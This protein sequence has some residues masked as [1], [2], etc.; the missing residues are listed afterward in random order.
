[1]SL[2]QE[3][4]PSDVDEVLKDFLS[5]KFISIGNELNQPS[6]FPIRK[7]MPYKAQIGDVHYF[8]NPATHNYDAAITVEGFWGLK[9]SGWV[10][11]G[12]SAV[13]GSGVFVQETAPSSPDDGDFWLKLSIPEL[14]QYM[15]AAWEPIPLKSDLADE[16][17]D[18]IITGGYF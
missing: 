17:G 12:Q 7:E 14:S 6:K 18:L 13:V 10:D 9:S 15:N 8:G 2:S 3:Q 11:L 16:I 4:P 1:M 5:R